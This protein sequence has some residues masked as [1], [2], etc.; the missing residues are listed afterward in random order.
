MENRYPASDQEEKIERVFI[1]W[2]SPDVVLC[3]LNRKIHGFMERM[4]MRRKIISKQNLANGITLLRIVG[5]IGL[6]P[7]R[8]LSPAFFAVYTL[9]G[10]TDVLD[11]WVARTTK[12]ASEFGAKLDSAADLLFY[13][14]ML[15]RFSPLFGEVLPWG[16][17]CAAAT[18]LAVRLAS[19]TVAAIKHRRF[20]SLHTYL[21]KL[22]GG[23]VFLIPYMIVTPYAGP[24][25]WA[26]C[27]IAGVSSLE[28]LV[29]HL[30]AKEYSSGVK[31]ILFK[32]DSPDYL[33][34]EEGKEKK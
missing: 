4:A 6:L 11:G 24:Y 33:F 12:T 10:L 34:A 20:A 8:L 23:A 13:A 9:T 32:K 31:S 21:N 3:S 25:L 18:V 22:T 17:W 27:A 5:T 1:R 26:V 29:I 28:E 2:L 7:L 14:V 16:M 15:I 19:Y 30:Q